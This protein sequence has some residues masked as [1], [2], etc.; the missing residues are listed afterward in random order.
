[1][2]K[3]IQDAARESMHKAI[4]EWPT[5]HSD[6]R[7]IIHL[8]KAAIYGPLIRRLHEL[9]PDSAKPFMEHY[10]FFSFDDKS[11]RE[12]VDFAAMFEERMWARIGI[13]IMTMNFS[14]LANFGVPDEESL[15]KALAEINACWEG[16]AGIGILGLGKPSTKDKA[17]DL[18][19]ITIWVI[20][21]VRDA[22]SG[23]F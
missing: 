5:R 12:K 1:M 14:V 16:I 17:S 11:D 22:R 6:L 21:P 15:N 10:F 20:N 7:D 3:T 4:H 2:N 18:V 13:N 19:S 9:I 23:F 8:Q